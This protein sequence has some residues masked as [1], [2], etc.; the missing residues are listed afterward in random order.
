MTK[1]KKLQRKIEDVQLALSVLEEPDKY[2]DKIARELNSY[3]VKVDT[4]DER[5]LE[6][7]LTYLLSELYDQVILENSEEK[8][9]EEKINETFSFLENGELDDKQ[10]FLK[11]DE[12]TGFGDDSWKR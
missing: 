1:M 5:T 7:L 9:L 10:L 8:T 6:Q 2:K 12:I 4:V 3:S 11:L